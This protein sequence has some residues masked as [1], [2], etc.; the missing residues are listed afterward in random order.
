MLA[1]SQEK[2]AC[3]IEIAQWVK[4]VAMQDEDLISNPQNIKTIQS[5]SSICN[6]SN[7]YM[8]YEKCLCMY[9]CVVGRGY[10]DRK[11]DKVE[12]DSARLSS[13]PHT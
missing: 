3:G 11:S 12:G 7:S 13:D 9:V 4:V 2:E 5:S 10:R 1:L 6:P 8:Y